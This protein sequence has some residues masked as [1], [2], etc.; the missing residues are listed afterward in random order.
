MMHETLI[1]HYK[2]D[3]LEQITMSAEFTKRTA[4]LTR[5]KGQKVW[6]VRGRLHPEDGAYTL[7]II[8]GVQKARALFA[9]KYFVNFG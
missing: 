6:S 5:I 1:S 7:E 4:L 9:A 8:K 2:D 3:T